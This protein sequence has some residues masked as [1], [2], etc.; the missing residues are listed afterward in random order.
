MALGGLRRFV[1]QEA[2]E[3]VLQELFP[4]LEVQASLIDQTELVLKK[5]ESKVAEVERSD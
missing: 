1:V 4:R 2:T 3:A 5:V